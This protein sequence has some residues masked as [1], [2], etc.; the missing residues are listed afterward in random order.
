VTGEDEVSRA[1]IALYMAEPFF[2]HMVQ[3]LARRVDE[4]TPTAAVSLGGAGIELRVNPRFFAGLA[5][6]ERVAV[7]KHEI[8][9]VVLKHLL[10]GPGK[11][12]R[13]W[14]LACDVVVNDLVGK[15]PLPEGAVT[16]ASFPGLR[17]PADATAEAVYKLL[18]AE[19]LGGSGEGHEPPADGGEG[20]AGDGA[21][22]KDDQPSSHSD[23]GGWAGRPGAGRPGA[24]LGEP[25]AAAASEAAIDGL[26]TRASDRLPPGGRGHLPDV[27]REAISQA[28]ERG[29]PRIDWRRTLRLF[30]AGA[31]RTRVVATVRRESPRYGTFP[32]TKIKR[33][34][35]LAVVID[36]SG[37][38]S[39]EVLRS[40]FDEIHAIW[41]TG[42]SVL[43]VACDAA[44]H[45]SFEYRGEVP[46]R[47]GGG[48][49]TAFQPAFDW[50]RASRRLRV[51]GCIYLTDGQGPAPQQGPGCKLLWVVTDPGGLGPHLRFGRS[52]VLDV[53]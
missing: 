16:R 1:I 49:G 2:A 32:G 31:G 8:L 17:I 4:S 45:G 53:S 35:R 12:P 26:I 48:G 29:K 46:V 6:E 52:V 51:D 20:A 24:G 21:G 42:A 40:F 18:L 36:T 13:L 14:N 38:V 10:R 30:A 9:H 39:E 25:H 7:I 37:S 34:H 44:V 33:L 50:L 28:R 22:G 41:R 23:H 11:H 27:V 15:W 3:G 5:R 43:V 19:S 47:L